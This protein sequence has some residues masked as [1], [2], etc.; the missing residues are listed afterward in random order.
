[1]ELKAVKREKSAKRKEFF[2]IYILWNFWKFFFSQNRDFGISNSIS[3]GVIEQRIFSVY[4][5]GRTVFSD[6][7][8][9]SFFF[10]IIELVFFEDWISSEVKIIIN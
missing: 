3:K 2:K 5:A 4:H 1:M 10:G 6:L 7:L 8:L 9:I